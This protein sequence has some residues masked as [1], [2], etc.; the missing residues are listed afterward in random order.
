MIKW[1]L[2][3]RQSKRIPI[4]G[5]R[6]RKRERERERERERIRKASITNCDKSCVALVSLLRGKAYVIFG[7][8]LTVIFG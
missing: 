2:Q 1:N 7:S 4:R 3:T 6:E 5:E 8:Q